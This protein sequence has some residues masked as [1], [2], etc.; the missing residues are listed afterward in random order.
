MIPLK[1]F[2]M[3]RH[4]QT[5]A[6]KER[7]MAGWTDSPLTEKGRRQAKEALTA[8]HALETKPKTIV[9]S[10]LSRA[11]DTAEILNTA[12]NAPIH[13]TKNLAEIHAGDWEGVSYDISYQPLVTGN[14][15]PG[16]ETYE[17]FCL[18]VARGISHYM[19][20]HDNPVLFV[21][22]GGVFRA[23]GMFYGVTAYGFKNCHLYE[24][25]P[26]PDSKT[27]PWIVWQY[28]IEGNTA[29]RRPAELFHPSKEEMAS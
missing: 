9:H 7:V 15:P 4:G 28:D 19:D 10:N 1:R 17:T 26:N 3:I 22:H 12:L 13:E 25:E 8:L 20:S 24:F 11:R 29:I 6:N 14:N 23:M 21:T 18:R 5:I 27:F 16:G 2:Y